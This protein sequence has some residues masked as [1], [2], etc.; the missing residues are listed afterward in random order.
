MQTKARQLLN[1]MGV[2]EF[3]F[4]FMKVYE[5]IYGIDEAPLRN[6]YPPYRNEFGE[7]S[8]KADAVLFFDQD[9][10]VYRMKN[11]KKGK[12]VDMSKYGRAA[13]EKGQDRRAYDGEKLD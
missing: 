6:K 9:G 12:K 2:E 10:K 13:R 7:V 11:G 5:E 3:K 4:D 8:S 1:E